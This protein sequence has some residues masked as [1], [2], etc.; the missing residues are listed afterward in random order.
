[1]PFD[2][3]L[4]RPVF[5]LYTGLTASG[6]DLAAKSAPPG[7]ML[8]ALVQDIRA[9]AWPEDALAYFSKARLGGQGVNPYWPRAAMLLQATFHLERKEPGGQIGYDD[10]TKVLTSV[11]RFPTAPGN[12]AA[13]TI[14]WVRQYPQFHRLVE[15]SPALRVLWSRFSGWMGPEQLEP[16]RA[17]AKEAIDW[18]NTG[19]GTTLADIPDFSVIPNPLQARQIADFVRKDGVLYAVL[20]NPRPQSIAHEILHTVFEKAIT[21]QREN[22]VARRRDLF[23]KPVAEAM[24]KM[25]Y[26]WDDGAE[27]WLRVFEETLVRAAT[28]WMAHRLNPYEGDKRALY[29][30]GDGFVY[31][32]ALLESFR[33]KWTGPEEMDAFIMESLDR[34]GQMTL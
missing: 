19:L 17:A 34:M 8:S 12:K 2:V 20:A 31:V 30:S 13:D 25:Q 4:S 32:P 3:S 23:T 33:E 26:A 29:E 24:V 28:I 5:V 10:E 21:R 7:G 14:E 16:F 22:I 1:V 27:S 15:E 11:S 6:Y 18:L 9:H